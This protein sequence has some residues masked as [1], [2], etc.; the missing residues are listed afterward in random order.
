M[1]TGKPK[2]SLSWMVISVLEQDV[3]ALA[4]AVGV[5]QPEPD[6]DPLHEERERMNRAGE[7]LSAIAFGVVVG[8]G[9]LWAHLVS[10]MP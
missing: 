4:V 10:L 7:R 1:D 5:L 2:N 8:T 3:E 6:A 9:L